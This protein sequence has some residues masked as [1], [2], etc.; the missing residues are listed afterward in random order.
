MFL[1]ALDGDGSNMGC[2]IISFESSNILQGLIRIFGL[3]MGM[4]QALE[5]SWREG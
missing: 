3:D 5:V 1:G 4:N 2:L